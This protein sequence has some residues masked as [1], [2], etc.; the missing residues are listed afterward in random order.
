MN[1]KTLDHISSP[2]EYSTGL[3]ISS[4][5]G[6]VRVTRECV[7]WEK[8]E[9]EIWKVSTLNSKSLK[10]ISFLVTYFKE[11]MRNPYNNLYIS[12]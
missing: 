2:V 8:E 4:V 3:S 10:K 12:S 7:L 11:V 1:Y 5:H 6:N 9:E